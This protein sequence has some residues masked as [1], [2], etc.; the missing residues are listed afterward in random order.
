MEEKENLRQ[1]VSD[2][3]SENQEAVWIIALL[4]KEIS[5]EK[6]D[7]IEKTVEMLVTNFIY[8]LQL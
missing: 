8:T 5:E 3:G 7:R 6:L 2:L 4:R 1:K